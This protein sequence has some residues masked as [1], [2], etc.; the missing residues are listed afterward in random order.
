M[1]QIKA[2]NNIRYPE[3]VKRGKYQREREEA[4]TVKQNIRSEVLFVAY[5]TNCIDQVK[6]KREKIKIAVK[7]A[8]KY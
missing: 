5:I 8:E 7:G 1:T 4:N 6:H 3:A 2:A